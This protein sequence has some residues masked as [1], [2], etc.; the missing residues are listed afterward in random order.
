M[1]KTPVIIYTKTDESPA[2]ATHSFLPI[3]R[4]YANTADITVESRDISLSGRILAVFPEYLQE[5]QRINDDLSELGELAKKPEANIIKLP[6]IS[7]SLPQLQAAIEELQSQGYNIP[8]YPM[9]PTTEEEK[10]IQKRYDK[11]KGSAVN[12]VLREGNSDRRAPKAVKN[13]AKKN[14]HKMGAWTA[15]SKSHVATMD[16]GDFF[17]NEKSTTLSKADTL[18][19]TFTDAQGNQTVLKENL[20]VLQDE[21]I[22]ATVMNKKALV[23]FLEQEIKDANEKDVLFSVH[24]KATMMKVSD[25]IIFGHVVKTYF[26]DLFEKHQE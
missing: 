17:H 12:P 20:K 16:S 7:A 1:K 10:E 26:A 9:N 4:A 8:N 14:P 5:D 15:D 21:V 22:D 18:K 3:V 2:M 19:I 24:L 23:N 13:Y 6:N 25:P 11:V